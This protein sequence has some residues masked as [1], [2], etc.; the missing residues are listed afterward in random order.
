M[1]VKVSQSCLTLCD[2]MDY[3]VHG[4]LQAKI[5]EW[6][7]FPFSSR[8]SHPKDWTQVYRI[9]GGFFTNWVWGKPA[10]SIYPFSKKDF[11]SELQEC[12]QWTAFSCKLLQ[13]CFDCNGPL[14]QS[15]GSSTAIYLQWLIDLGICQSAWMRK[16]E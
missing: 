2:A 9:A 4:I 6:V 15:Y 7:V 1:K 5:L 10:L 13:G 12:C 8:C 3:R 11:F 14:A 16:I